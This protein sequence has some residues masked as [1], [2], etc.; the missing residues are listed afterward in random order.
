MFKTITYRPLN[1]YRQ[2]KEA[3]EEFPET[4]IILDKSYAAF[5]QLPAES[6]YK[7]VHE[8]ILQMSG[9]MSAKGIAKGDKVMLY[10][11]ASFETYLLAVA[12]TYLGAVPVMVSYHLSSAT[13]DVFAKRLEKSFI[14]YDDETAGRVSDMLAKDLVTEISV[15]ELLETEAVAVSENLLA[16]DIIQYMTHTS[17]TTGIPKL[18]CH[19]GQSMGWRVAWQQTIFVKMKERGLLA[20]HI[21]PVH[22]RYNIGISSAI[23]LGFPIFPLSSAQASEV[24]NQLKTYKPMALETHPNNFVQWAR[25]AKEKPVVFSSVKFY[26]STFDAINKATMKAFLI[27]SKANNPVFMQVYGQSECGPMILRYHRLEGIDKTNARDM[28]VGLEGYTQ[29]RVTDDKGQLLEAGQNGHIQ[30][31]S[32]G[33]AI[34]YYKEDARFQENVYDDW[35]DSGDYGCL[36][37]EGTLLLKDRQVDVIDQID[38]NLALEDMLMDQLDF[39]SEVVIIRDGDGRPQ[40]ILALAEGAS[41][42]WEAWWSAVNDLPLLKEPVLMAY[43]DIPRTAT[44][45]VQRLQMEAKLKEEGNL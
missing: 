43:E 16:E 41:M 37:E 5:P 27:A 38:S 21:S 10:K 23:N 24:E 31:F 35:W 33:R 2:F 8:A 34:T 17:G 39:L 29:A 19:T 12:A 28:G 14:V 26:H 22:S 9:R 11:S 4:A 20:F 3:A 40:P 42:N 15:A 32:K 18:I 25:L 6:T 44:M 30:L 45:K 13:L 7:E 1:L 36:T